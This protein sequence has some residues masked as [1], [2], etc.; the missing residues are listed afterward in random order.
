MS[1]DV[2]DTDPVRPILSSARAR[3]SGVTTMSRDDTEVDD[4]VMGGLKF[5][6]S[7]KSWFKVAF[8]MTS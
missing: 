4:E 2:A 6:I 5:R 1:R 7:F 8:I 3:S